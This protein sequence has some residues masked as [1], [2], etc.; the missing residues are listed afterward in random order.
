MHIRQYCSDDKEAVWLLHNLAL[1]GTGAHAGN[2]SWDQD[3]HDIPS[4]YISTGGG[5]L[6]GV[7]DYRLIAMGA[8]MLSD[9]KTAEIKRMRVHPDYQGRGCGNQILHALE[10]L[11]AAL[12]YRKLILETT[13]VQ[14]V[15]QS[16]YEKN[17]YQIIHERDEDGFHILRYGKNAQLD[18]A[19]ESLTRPAGL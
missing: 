12:G 18:A 19:S 7:L 10:E 14:K 9:S 8:I 3:L 4:T 5:F 15:A 13:S 11:A 1:E 6:V 2:G 17:G 16:L